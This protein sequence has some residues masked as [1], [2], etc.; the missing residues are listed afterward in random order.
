MAEAAG[1]SPIEVCHE[2]GIDSP[3]TLYKVYNDEPV[4]PKTR[5][6]VEQAIK[7]LSAKSQAEAG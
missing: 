4:R 5:I 7:R 6:K 3:K 2:A 1:A